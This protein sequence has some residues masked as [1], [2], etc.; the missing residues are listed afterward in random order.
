MFE[1]LVYVVLGGLTA[2]F[3]FLAIL[4]ALNRRAHRLARKRMLALFPMSIDELRAEKDGIRAE[5]ALKYVKFENN[6]RT[7]NERHTQQ[8]TKLG[9]RA[10]E[11][12]QLEDHIVALKNTIANFEAH[13]AEIKTTLT[14]RDASLDPLNAQ[15]IAK[16]AEIYARQLDIEQRDQALISAHNTIS[17]KINAISSLEGRVQSVNTHLDE[18]RLQLKERDTTLVKANSRVVALEQTVSNEAQYAKSLKEKLSELETIKSEQSKTL[19]AQT[20]QIKTATQ[21]LNNTITELETTQSIRDTLQSDLDT[22]QKQLAD[23][24]KQLEAFMT[25]E[26]AITNELEMLKP[27]YEALHIKLSESHDELALA[28][29]AIDDLTESLL[30]R[31]QLYKN[32]HKSLEDLQEKS[33]KLTNTHELLK[34]EYG[35]TTSDFQAVSNE[36]ERKKIHLEQINL[37]FSTVQNQNDKLSQ[38]IKE[39]QTQHKTLKKQHES[40][41][42]VHIPLLSAYETV[43]KDYDTAQAAL[44]IALQQ[45]DQS[46][47]KLSEMT[48]K[49]K[50]MNRVLDLRTI[51]LESA[52]ASISTL[53]SMLED[54]R[55]NN[56]DLKDKTSQSYKELTENKRIK[57]MNDNRISDLSSHIEKLS[58][59]I[60]RHT[61]EVAQKDADIIVMNQK[62][63]TAELKLG[64]LKKAVADYQAGENTQ[65]IELREENLALQDT[66]KITRAERNEVKEVLATL[67]IE[68]EKQKALREAATREFSKKLADTFNPD[69]FED[70]QQLSDAP[71]DTDTRVA[72]MKDKIAQLKTEIAGLEASLKKTRSDREFL[73]SEL[74]ESQQKIQ[75]AKVTIENDNAELRQRIEDLA[76]VI[77]TLVEDDP[78]AFDIITLPSYSEANAR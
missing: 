71:Q 17:L 45:S 4:P 73:R 8:L 7:L 11:I 50:E 66:L 36:I 32:T 23:N 2:S 27:E 21:S 64:T 44:N 74:V 30:E 63:T 34:N 49:F 41:N 13:T 47:L 68:Q 62:L 12:T 37:Q 43:S 55:T 22:A 31:T 35:K 28:K 67:Q 5:H 16:G 72:D 48:G 18:L 77:L 24:K 76:E 53:E 56:V 78:K 15:L 26:E 14:L 38:T 70:R 9:K 75:S 19:R 65:I 6:I 57:K 33:Q 61:T 46:D 25:R 52:K 29:T 3:L 42:Q 59:E 51:S 58:G 39:L 54:E 69:T 10:Q 1:A 20:I 40:L 60:M